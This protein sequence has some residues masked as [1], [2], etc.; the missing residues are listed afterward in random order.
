MVK[1]VI[2][3]GCLIITLLSICIINNNVQAI[4]NHGD[5]LACFIIYPEGSYGVGDQINFTLLVFNK[6]IP[7]DCD[8]IIFQFAT[9]NSERNISVNHSSIGVYYSI[10]FLQQHDLNHDGTT[11]IIMIAIWN[12][13]TLNEKRVTDNYLFYSNQYESFNV[14]I[15]IPEFIDNYP[16]PGQSIEFDIR[17]SFMDTLVNPD[18]GFPKVRLYDS[19][20]YL[21]QLS[22]NHV[23]TG[24]FKG[25]FS[26]ESDK[27]NGSIYKLL[28]ECS[29]SPNNNVTNYTLTKTISYTIPLTFINIWTRY[30]EVDNEHAVVQIGSTTRSNI[31]ISNVDISITCEFKDID[32]SQLKNYS[33]V[34]N[35][36]GISSF[37]IFYNFSQ[38]FFNYDLT[39]ILIHGMAENND[40]HQLFS[41]V[42]TVQD[43]IHRGD[44]T[45][46]GIALVTENSFFD[47]S[48]IKLEYS[49]N[50]SNLHLFTGDIII[51]IT[52]NKG[53]YYSNILDI[54]EFDTFSIS[55]N[56]PPIISDTLYSQ[57][58]FVWF[59]LDFGSFWQRIQDDIIIINKDYPGFMEFMIDPG[60][61]ITFGQIIS[62]GTINVTL[63][64]H[65]KDQE[66]KVFGIIWGFGDYTNWNSFNHIDWRSLSQFSSITSVRTYGQMLGITS[67]DDKNSITIQIPPFSSNASKIYIIGFILYSSNSTLEL[68]YCYVDNIPIP[69]CY[70]PPFIEIISPDNGSRYTEK[71]EIYGYIYSA[72]DY[73]QVDVRIDDEHW[74]NVNSTN[75]LSMVYNL[76]DILS[77]EHI[78]S[79]RISDGIESNITSIRFIK[80][81]IPGVSVQTPFPGKGYP[82]SLKVI[83]SASDNNIVE[84]VEIRIDDSEWIRVNGTT[85]WSYKLRTINSG[86]HTL[87][88]RSFDGYFYS[89]ISKVSFHTYNMETRG[90]RP[91][92]LYIGVVLLVTISL[93]ILLWTKIIKFNNR[94]D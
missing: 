66:E 3:Y 28:V 74:E 82:M 91:I 38:Y 89:D 51:Y 9:Y 65:Y 8:T 47:S 40:I 45:D 35:E 56:T 73:A 20:L 1:R 75:V 52:D 72:S 77:G 49:V 30:V 87:E 19:N 61:N 32:G 85:H 53:V 13:G 92:Y 41:T 43:Y 83:G 42:L 36:Y 69:Y 29:Y 50:R 10:P 93:L 55:F 23:K 14:D 58:L 94:I 79:I 84:Y 78:V 80:D 44:V 90:N 57:K 37:T 67:N 12:P 26:I 88:C 6:G 16:I 63:D 86:N 71:L 39:S 81:C 17:C 2:I 46:S 70:L 24:V 60:M 54:E 4:P 11:Q 48:P 7:T 22:L 64:S 25:S 68:K 34:T 18:D 33:I 59:Q 15:F 21:G 76:S 62:N 31:P 5:S 27:K